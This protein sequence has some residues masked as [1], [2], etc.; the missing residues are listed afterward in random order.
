MNYPKTAEDNQQKSK[1]LGQK[2]NQRS[3]T[4]LSQTR[5][6]H[7]VLIV[8]IND[9]F[10][11]MNINWSIAQKNSKKHLSCFRRLN[12]VDNEITVNQ[13]KFTM[14]FWLVLCTVKYGLVSE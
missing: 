10:A 3:G 12:Y 4:G 7:F 11:E 2:V 8:V 14:N 5:P 9:F 6:R 1:K 13:T